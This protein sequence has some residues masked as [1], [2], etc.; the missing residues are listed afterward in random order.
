MVAKIDV[1]SL[2]KRA[3]EER[4]SCSSAQV[5]NK[6][7][8]ALATETVRQH[9]QQQT[10][11]D[12]TNASVSTDIQELFYLPEFLNQTEELQILAAVDAAPASRWI[13]AGERKMQNWGGIPGESLVREKLPQFLQA[14]VEL[15]LSAGIF[16]PEQTPQHVLVNSYG[17][18]AGIPAHTDGPLYSPCV[19]TI[20][21]SGPALMGFHKALPDGTAGDLVSQVMLQPR[22]LL[23][24]RGQACSS[25]THSI[26]SQ[27]SDVVCACCSNVQAARVHVGQT[28]HRAQRRVSLVF[29]HKQ[30]ASWQC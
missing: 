28:V 22:C 5:A 30:H 9:A 19:A 16:P 1:R 8:G 27:D 6:S 14:L 25:H 24:M 18:S 3:K 29:V 11:L 13:N 4:K 20:T 21:L 7:Y 12:L 10:P 15:L 2:V 23:L 26:A 17:K